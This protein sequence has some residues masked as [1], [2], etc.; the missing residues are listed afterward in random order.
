MFAT[1]VQQGQFVKTSQEQTG[2]PDQDSLVALHAGLP[3]F[4]TLTHENGQE[5]EVTR[6]R[7]IEILGTP[8]SG[9]RLSTPK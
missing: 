8:G 7:A 1:N 3:D 6:A 4:V 2:A 9:Y 5:V